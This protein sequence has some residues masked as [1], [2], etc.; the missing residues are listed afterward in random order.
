VKFEEPGW[1]PAAACC[2]IMLLALVAFI[3]TVSFSLSGAI[4]W[5]RLR[6]QF[7]GKLI[8]RTENSAPRNLS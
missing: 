2:V 5:T 3:F 7:L 8:R 4:R 6:L 1:I